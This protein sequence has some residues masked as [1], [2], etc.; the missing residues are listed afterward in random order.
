MSE[1][2]VSQRAARV[3]PEQ[4]LHDAIKQAITHLEAAQV[5]GG[6][7]QY[8]HTNTACGLLEAALDQLLTSDKV[9]SRLLADLDNLVEPS[10]YEYSPA[11]QGG[12]A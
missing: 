10:R 3:N 7:A 12:A 5:T 6:R 2:N 11:D 4:P 9:V 8:I 1:S